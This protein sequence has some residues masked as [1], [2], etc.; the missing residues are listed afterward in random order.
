MK[1]LTDKTDLSKEKGKKIERDIR[2]IFAS[3]F[4]ICLLVSVGYLLY[5][6]YEIYETDIS[7]LDSVGEVWHYMGRNVVAFEAAILS[8]LLFVVSLKI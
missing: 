1:T 8:F 4:A 2:I 5:T 6:V 7:S 3:F